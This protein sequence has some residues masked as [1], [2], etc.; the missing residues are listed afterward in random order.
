MAEADDWRIQLA[1]RIAPVYA[2][3]A[4]VQA[5]VL[6]GGV[7][8]G[9]GDA[10][11]DLDIVVFWDGTPGEG[12]RRAALAQVERVLQ[13][14]LVVGGLYAAPVLGADAD[15]MLWEDEAFIGGDAASGFKLD[16]GHRTVNAMT[17]ILNDVTQ[18]SDPHGHKQEVLYSI[19]RV[20]VLH[21]EALVRQWQRQAAQFPDALRTKLI[22]QHLARIKPDLVMHLYRG[23]L[24]LVYQTLVGVQHDLLG[25]LFA[26]NRIHRPGYKR[27]RDLC[28]EIPIKPPELYD[29]LNALLRDD[30]AQ[31]AGD[32]DMLVSEVFALVE[33]HAPEVDIATARQR[34]ATRRQPFTTPPV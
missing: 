11:S 23:D 3:I 17:L 12:E 2:A 13:T 21:G 20:L 24:L 18:Y 19:Q 9:R 34:C 6:V 10:Y 14:P 22:E 15:G 7:A 8:R 28:D 31:A 29:R 30:P 16:I 33:Q 26:L 4:R 27:L 1:R 5:V 32:L 25:V